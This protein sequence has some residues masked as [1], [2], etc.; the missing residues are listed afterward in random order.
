MLDDDKVLS[1]LT[2]FVTSTQALARD[3]RNSPLMRSFT[4]GCSH[5]DPIV[6]EC[7]KTL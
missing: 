1:L 5:K 4:D 6:K 3:S 2:G 7:H